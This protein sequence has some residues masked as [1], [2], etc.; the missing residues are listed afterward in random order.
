VRLLLL[1]L[2]LAGCG[3]GFHVV[4]GDMGPGDAGQNGFAPV[5]ELVDAGAPGALRAVWGSAAGPDVHIAGDDGVLFD[6][7]G[8]KWTDTRVGKGVDFSGL[9]GA[10]PDDIWAVGTFRSTSKGLMMHRTQVGWIEFGQTT[11]G[12]KSVWGVGNYRYAVGLSGAIY[13]GSADAPF[14]MGLQQSRNMLVPDSM[15]APILW[16][17]S[18]NSASA[19]MVAADLDTY[20]FF[21]TAWHQYTD[22][23]DRTRTFRTVWGAPDTGLRLYLGANYF[24]IWY[25]TGKQNPVLQLNEE[26]DAP[27]N[28]GKY[29]WSIWGPSADKVIC[30]G[31]EGRIMTFDAATGAV[32]TQPSPT[33]ANLYG[34]WGRSLE[35]V[36]IVGD[37]GLILHGRLVF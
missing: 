36:W 34:V 2:A 24:G 30:V 25:F 15:F 9:W 3:K 22:P 7:D 19:V 4:V 11:F 37:G 29:I 1:A 31:D 21:D 28:D 17:V 12:L 8:A 18:G 16:S 26:R 5:A 6:W 32:K 27:G 23:V 35:D 33:S 14:A 20:F 10:A 13:G